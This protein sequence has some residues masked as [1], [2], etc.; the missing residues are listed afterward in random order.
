MPASAASTA[1]ESRPSTAAID[2]VPAGAASAMARPR[3]TTALI[4]C[5]DPTAPDAASAAYSPTECPA[6]AAGSMPRRFKSSV[7]PSPTKHN[8]GCAFCVSLNSSSSALTSSRCKSTPAASPHRSQSLATS[9]SA[10]SSAPMPAC[11]E[12]WPGKTKATLGTVTSAG[13]HLV[14]GQPEMFEQE[15]GDDPVSLQLVDALSKVV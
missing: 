4:T 3:S 1:C 2:P 13:S 8:A 15:R 12:P 6:A 5:G 7:K 14:R 11:C 9:G 10:S